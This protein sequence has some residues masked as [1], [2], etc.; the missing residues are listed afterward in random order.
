MDER[1]ELWLSG[2]RAG[3]LMECGGIGRSMARR[4]LDAGLA[5]EPERV[6]RTLMYE[7][8]RIAGLLLRPD[9]DH[10]A[11]P[12]PAD[13][14]L[15]R[16]RVQRRDPWGTLTNCGV[17]AALQIRYAAER[18]GFVPMVVTC[19]GFVVG[20]AEVTGARSTHLTT[21]SLAMGPAGGWFEAFRDRQFYSP[22]GNS[23]S[24]EV[25]P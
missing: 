9:V 1:G 23:W 14:V 13:Q 16:R 15:L 8:E 22:P 10:D 6:G 19:C 25:A 21:V 20:G 5:G 12:P 4:I 3:E 11:L 24:L 7:A 2:R 17:M 18:H